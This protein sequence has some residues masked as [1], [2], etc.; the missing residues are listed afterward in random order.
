M[1]AWL[2]SDLQA[3]QKQCTIAYFHHPLFSSSERR[4]GSPGH[5][6]AIWDLLYYYAAD[7]VVNGHEHQYERSRPKTQTG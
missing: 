7:V 2:E 1:L 6:K 3:N 4:G 5:A